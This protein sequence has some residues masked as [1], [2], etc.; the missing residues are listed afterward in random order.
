MSPKIADSHTFDLK[1]IWRTTAS[2]VHNPQNMP[3]NKTTPIKPFP[4]YAK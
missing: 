2:Y 3:N 4:G 1:F